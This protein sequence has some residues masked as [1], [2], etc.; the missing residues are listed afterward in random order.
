MELWFSDTGVSRVVMRNLLDAVF[1]EETDRQRLLAAFEADPATAPYSEE[2][3]YLVD[4][5]NNLLLNTIDMKFGFVFYNNSG[6]DMNS[7]LEG[8]YKYLYD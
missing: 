1:Y 2:L 7:L 8:M 3:K 6:E 5:I 4:N